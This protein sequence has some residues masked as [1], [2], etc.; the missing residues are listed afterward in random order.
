MKLLKI[1]PLR[2]FLLFCIL[3]FYGYNA[4]EAYITWIKA[5]EWIFTYH[6]R[7]YLVSAFCILPAVL[8]HTATIWGHYFRSD[9]EF[10]H[11]LDKVTTSKSPKEKTSLWELH[12]WWGYTVKYWVLVGAVVLIQLGWIAIVVSST[13]G[14]ELED[15]EITVQAIIGRKLFTPCLFFCW[16]CCF[17]SRPPW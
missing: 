8:G 4:G 16:Y 10:Q 15:P 5:R 11:S 14:D 6:N 9:R 3:V 1:D 13:L 12:I 17:D 2:A 7:D